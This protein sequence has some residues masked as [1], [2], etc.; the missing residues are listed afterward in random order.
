MADSNNVSRRR[1]LQATGG[2]AAAAALAGCSGGDGG[3]TTTTSGGNNTNATTQQT[4]V[5]LEGTT[6]NMIAS[7]ITTFDP[8][9]ATD[10]ESG[11]V[12]QQ[13]FDCLMQYPQA[14]TSVTGELATDFSVSDDY[15]TYTFTLADA[16]YHNGDSLKA[17]DFVY[18]WERLVASDKSRRAYFAL[19]SIGIKHE[20]DSDGNYKSGTL[21]VTAVDDSTLKV[22]LEE[23]FHATK[24]ML[25]Y[26][27]FAPVPEGIVGDIDGYDGEMEYNKFA[28]EKPIGNGPFE[29]NTYSKGTEVALDKYDDYYG[30]KAAADHI[31]WQIIED[32]NAYYE[33]TMNKNADIVND[34]PTSKYDPKKVNVDHTT[35]F[36]ADVGTY[37]PV[38]NGET[39]NYVG[40]TPL[41]T[42]YIGFNMKSVPKPV[43]QAFAYAM[44]QQTMVQ[45]VFKNR[46]TPAYFLTP[47]TIFPGGPSAAKDLA[48]N[49]YPY[50]YNK[51]KIA[52]ARQVMEDAGYSESKKF[53]VTFTQYDSDSWESM[54]KILRDQLASAH[55]Q[56]NIQR[57]PFS[58]LTQRGRQGQLEAY[59][60]GWVADWP[61]ADNFLQLLNPPQTDTSLK[62][63]I[64]YLNW[65]AENGDAAEKATKAYQ[66]VRDN[67]APTDEAQQKRDA[68]YKKMEKANWEDVG[69]LNIYNG[70][71]EVMWYD[72]VE[73][74]KP[75][76]GMGFSRYKLNEVSTK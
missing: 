52:K 12:I 15:T 66:T 49:E 1:F 44:N 35:D 48:K 45:E 16:T 38:R 3:E 68:A 43:R 11:R 18:A 54:A 19:D 8:V 47:P 10:T 51:S 60:L 46:G 24:E 7:T 17:S 57:V 53:N 69:F 40:N 41:N 72:N 42:Y 5:D 26:T 29:M 71:R 75:F 59:S 67:P 9:A 39:M 65:T 36:G 56:M 22:E 13:V 76:G 70:L 50:G 58:T 4:T 28:S 74:L 64:S 25:A 20:K 6:V 37:G 27:S 73:G 2:A 30:T 33:F 63:P 34:F 32:P 14:K 21:G 55:I 62:G 23:P 31:H 61:A